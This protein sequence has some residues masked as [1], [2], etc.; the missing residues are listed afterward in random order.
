MAVIVIDMDAVPSTN[1]AGV[2]GIGAAYGA[3]TRNLRSH[4]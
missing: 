2:T 3:R 4:I 1:E